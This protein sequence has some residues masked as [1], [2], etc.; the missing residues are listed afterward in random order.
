MQLAQAYVRAIAAGLAPIESGAA[1]G[2]E[3][4]LARLA[5][6][7]EWVRARLATVPPEQR[8]LVTSHDAFG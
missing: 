7:E 4:Y 1:A 3:R 2:A 5:A 6:L 8:V